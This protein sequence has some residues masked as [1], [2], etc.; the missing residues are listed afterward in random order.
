MSGPELRLRDAARAVI[1][2]PASRI[3]LV[4]FE[5]PDRTVWASPSGG[6]PFE[7]APLLTPEQLRDEYVS[8]VRWWTAEELAGS[9]ERHAPRRLP[10]LVA[11]LRTSGP[12]AERIDAGV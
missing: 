8:H 6:E 1:L 7:P 10:G 5:S 12:P 4:R 11:S 9:T 3:L 2:D